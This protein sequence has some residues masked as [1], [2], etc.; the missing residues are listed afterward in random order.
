M[1]G[2]FFG[3]KP[4]EASDAPVPVEDDADLRAAFQAEP[5]PEAAPVAQSGG[6]E[7]AVSS[8]PPA[9]SSKQVAKYE[10]LG[11]VLVVTVINDTLSGREARELMTEV[12]SRSAYAGRRADA[13]GD[14][15]DPG[16]LPRHFVLDLQNVDYMDSGC[17]GA[18]VELL[19]SM[20]SRSGRIA[21]VNAGRNVEYLFR[22]TQLDRLFPI[23]R[24]V[25]SA[26][27][28]V[29]RGGGADTGGKQKKP[30]KREWI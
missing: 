18:M 11:Q 8:K 21:L 20:Q 2:K 14:G 22:L 25:M 6:K 19:Q 15:I 13:P 27:D 26:I 7:T 10:Q 12:S 17:L 1:L 9:A 4:V 28:A 16:S 3:K 5:E 30:K 23:C 24:D 29:E